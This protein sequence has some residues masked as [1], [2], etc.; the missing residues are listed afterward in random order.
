MITGS[1]S[2][3]NTTITSVTVDIVENLDKYG[4]SHSD[5]DVGAIKP[6]TKFDTGAVI[7]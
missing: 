7:D 1:N 4:C 3:S 5:F 6:S 2:S